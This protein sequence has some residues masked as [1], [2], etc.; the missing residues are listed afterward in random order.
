MHIYNTF[1]ALS[2]VRLLDGHLDKLSYRGTLL[3]KVKVWVLRPP[4]IQTRKGIYILQG[5]GGGFNAIMQNIDGANISR[6]NSKKKHVASALLQLVLF[7]D[8][9]MCGLLTT[10]TLNTV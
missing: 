7:E 1:F 5:G 4:L 6:T 10:P 8:F 2:K 9:Y 3:L